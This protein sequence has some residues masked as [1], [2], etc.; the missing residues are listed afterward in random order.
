MFDLQQ[1]EE[2][3]VRL[4]FPSFAFIQA[5][6]T[7]FVSCA[8]ILFIHLTL[9]VLHF[10]IVGDHVLFKQT[11]SRGSIISRRGLVQEQFQDKKNRYSTWKSHE[12]C[13]MMY[14]R[15]M[16]QYLFPNLKDYEPVK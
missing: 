11:D 3:L 14:K 5:L 10:L 16:H 6:N 13:H 9:H 12:T 4:Q 7:Q 1:V 15:S 2:M 8:Q